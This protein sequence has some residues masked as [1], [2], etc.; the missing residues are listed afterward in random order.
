MFAA[1]PAV[2]VIAASLEETVKQ[3]FEDSGLS[4]EQFQSKSRMI[5]D[6]LVELEKISANIEA[7]SP[8]LI[9]GGGLR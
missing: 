3:G 6:I 8:G 4:A 5:A 7:A 9:T 1:S 2:Q